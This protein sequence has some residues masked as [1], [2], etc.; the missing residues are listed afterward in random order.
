MQTQEAVALLGIKRLSRRCEWIIYTIR[1]LPRQILIGGWF[2][3]VV[4]QVFVLDV[5]RNTCQGFSG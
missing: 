3:A 2:T 4:L 1:A 5:P